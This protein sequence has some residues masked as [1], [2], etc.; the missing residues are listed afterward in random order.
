MKNMVQSN[1]PPKT[2]LLIKPTVATVKAIAGK[3][4]LVAVAGSTCACGCSC[5][6]DE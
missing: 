1:A 3:I 5:H 6:V 2:G 4:D